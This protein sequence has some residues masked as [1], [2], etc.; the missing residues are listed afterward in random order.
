MD[1]TINILHLEDDLNDSLFIKLWLNK[2]N[3]NFNYFL[4][5]NETDFRNH[6]LSQKIDI[7]LSDYNLPD[8]SG[9][10]ALLLIKDLYPHIPFVFVSGTMGEEAA[11]QS[12][13]N[14]ATDY[15]LK[16]R[17]ERLGSAIKRALRESLLQKEYKKAID[18]LRQKEEQYRILI[19]GMNEG[20]MLTDINNI[21]LFVNQQACN[22]TGYTSDELIGLDSFDLLF[23]S[24][25]DQEKQKKNKLRVQGVKDICEI[26]IQRNDDS[27]VWIRFSA[28]PVFNESKQVTGSIGV[29]ENIN[30][31]KKAEEDIRKL[32]L[33]V[34][35]SPDSIIITDTE[36]VIEYANPTT[37]ALTGFTAEELY[38][39]KTSIFSSGD[40]SEINYEELWETIK[41][42]QIWNGE[43]LNQK[44]NGEL[45]WESATISPICNQN[46]LITNF[47][48]IKEDITDRKNLTRE[49]ILAKEKA[50]ES[51]RLKSA[52]LANISHE[53]RTPM[54]GILGFSELLKNP[55]L[56]PEA[57][58]RYIQIIEQSGNRMLSII[59]DIV[60]ISKIESGQMNL[61][62]NK[63]NVNHLL[64]ELAVLFTPEAQAKE[65]R[66][67]FTTALPNEKS[68]IQTDRNKLTQV[69]TNLIKNSLKFTKEGSINFGYELVDDYLEFYVKDTG[70]GIPADQTEIIFEQ[71]R[72]GSISLTRAYEGAGLGLSISKAFVEMLGGTIWVETKLGQGSVFY[73][74]IP[75]NKQSQKPVHFEEGKE[76]TPTSNVITILIAEDDVNSL[77][78]LRTL[79]E[80]DGLK[81]LEAANGQEAVEAVKDHPEISLVLIDMK[82]PIMNGFE[83]TRLIKQI[84]PKLPVIAQTAYAF[85]KDQDEALQ[86]GCDDY[87]SKPIKKQ[88]LMDKIHKLLG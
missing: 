9:A 51:D 41:S 33:A 43:F 45:Y 46:G 78:F 13:L 59:T 26:E 64:S 14:G 68:F 62:S 27:K 2:E 65:L 82:M 16:N 1:H 88:A 25:S 50:E 29:F 71:F 40:K 44:K 79:L 38:G 67:S 57:K 53:I 84:R 24:V 37:V 69:L 36:G 66:L 20:L 11:I 60:D 35:Q 77:M 17:L 58:N 76:S 73:F 32:T 34:E 8:Y 52:F 87:I 42:G 28:S 75:Y 47:L 39:K 48:A 18:T 49:L 10:D 63:I 19:E 70:V 5:D 21:I 81:I 55:Q 85:A 7:I 31:R 22:I 80:L 86:A 30:D 61:E 83:A 72:Q 54:N 15:V 56:L 12:L 3:L 4:A 23:S 74:R 6:L